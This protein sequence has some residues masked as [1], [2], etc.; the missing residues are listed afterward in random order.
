M[1]VLQHGRQTIVIFTQVRGDVI[2]IYLGERVI[3]EIFELHAGGRVYMIS[4][5]RLGHMH[6]QR[7]NYFLLGNYREMDR[8]RRYFADG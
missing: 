6:T 4:G 1:L 7:N 5:P 8:I 2:F 3:A